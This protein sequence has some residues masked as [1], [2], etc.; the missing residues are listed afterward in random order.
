[1]AT[2]FPRL[3]LCAAS[4]SLRLI[5]GT[6]LD[7]QDDVPDVQID[8]GLEVAH[9]LRGIGDSHFV[10]PFGYLELGP[11]RWAGG[12]GA[13][14]RLT[15]IGAGL[16][17]TGRISYLPAN[18]IVAAWVPSGAG[19]TGLD[20]SYRVRDLRI[21][22][23]LVAAGLDYSLSRLGSPVTPELSVELGL[24][25]YGMSWSAS[26]EEEGQPL[27]LPAA[28]LNQTDMILRLGGGGSLPLWG[29]VAWARLDF[30]VSRLGRE[31]GRP[32]PPAGGQLST[33]TPLELSLSAGVRLGL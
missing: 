18:G 22:R 16:R 1:M 20:I 29:S 10:E 24:R 11:L 25:R 23:F 30:G 13:K 14:L 15:P 31:R 28:N 6:P 9:S 33:S 26:G 7:A 17:P 8:V 21:D 32:R 12:V 27:H 3:L 4:L 2:P 19:H 5:L